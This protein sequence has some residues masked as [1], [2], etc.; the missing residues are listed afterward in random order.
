MLPTFSSSSYKCPDSLPL[1]LQVRLLN[2]SE[3][4]MND[5]SGRR[6]QRDHAVGEA[7]Q[8]AFPAALVLDGFAEHDFGLLAH[9]TFEVPRFLKLTF[10]PGGADLQCIAVPRDDFLNVEDGADLLRDEL[11]FFVRD[12]AARLV[13]IDTDKARTSG[14]QKFDVYDLDPFRCADA[15]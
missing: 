4:K 6:L 15:L 2:L 1:E 7:G 13:N 5:F 14:A 12:A 9:E 11:A 10:Q 8:G 3:W